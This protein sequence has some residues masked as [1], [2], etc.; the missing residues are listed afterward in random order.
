MVQSMDLNRMGLT[1]FSATEQ[2][3][4]NGGNWATVW[5]VIEKVATAISIGDAVDRFV[6]GWNSVE[7]NCK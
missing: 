7:C 6:N 1:E 2:L 5:K 4:T 3:N